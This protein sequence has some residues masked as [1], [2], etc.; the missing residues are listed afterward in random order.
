M[1]CPCCS[2]DIDI[3]RFPV[4]G[5]QQVVREGIRLIDDLPTEVFVKPFRDTHDPQFHLFLLGL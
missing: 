4:S 1:A 5:S 2:L 3:S